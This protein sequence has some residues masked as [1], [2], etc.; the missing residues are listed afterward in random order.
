MRHEL[1][2][3]A[4]GKPVEPG[5]WSGRAWNPLLQLEPKYL[6]HVFVMRREF[7]LPHL[8]ELENKWPYLAEF[9]LKG[10]LCLNLDAPPPNLD[11]RRVCTSLC[12]LESYRKSVGKNGE[13]VLTTD[14]DFYRYLQKAGGRFA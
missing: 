4:E 3:N 11:N 2:I 5:F 13:L 10:L 6:H 14:S 8:D 1:L 9:A 7:V 12:T